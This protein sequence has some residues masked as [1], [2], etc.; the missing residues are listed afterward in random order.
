MAIAVCK[1]TVVALWFMHLIHD[2]RFNRFVFASAGFFLLVFFA[3]TMFDLS[4]RGDIL[5][6]MDND[7]LRADQAGV[8][9]PSA[10]PAH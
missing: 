2:T 5:Q 6:I 10:A 9:A 1:A 4:T 3:F 8:P 7:V